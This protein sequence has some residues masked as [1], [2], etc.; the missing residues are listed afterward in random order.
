MQYSNKLKM[1]LET[2]LADL[3]AMDGADDPVIAKAIADKK[4]ERKQKGQ[5]VNESG[6]RF[7]DIDINEF[8]KRIRD[9][10]FRHRRNAHTRMSNI[11][12]HL[13]NLFPDIDKESVDFLTAEYNKGQRAATVDANNSDYDAWKE[14]T[15]AKRDGHYY[16]ECIQRAE[17]SSNPIVKNH[18]LAKAAAL[19]ESANITESRSTNILGLIGS[20]GLGQLPQV[21][22]IVDIRSLRD[23]MSALVRTTDGN[24]YEVQIRQAAHTQHP[25]LKK[26][27]EEE[28]IDESKFGKAAGAL[29][30]A[31][32]LWGGAELTSAKHTP[33]GQALQQAAQAG[34]QEAAYHLKKL[35]LYLDAGDSRT[36]QDLKNRYLDKE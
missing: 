22:K 29:A 11:E 17:K 27:T 10:G 26:F 16:H 33:L 24:A 9:M 14:K 36:M 19:Q 12:T 2:T 28:A 35:D 3:E 18:Y 23:G 30:I 4:A 34:D 32:A 7:S 1:L 31:A 15:A 25:E 8:A 13:Q 5:P 6:K 21:E 20:R